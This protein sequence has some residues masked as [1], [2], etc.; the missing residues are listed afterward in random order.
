MCISEMEEILKRVGWTKKVL[1]EKVDIAAPSVSRW[2]K[3]PGPVAAYLRLVDRVH[4]FYREA[5]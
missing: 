3:V 2:E 4:G 5:V 1:A